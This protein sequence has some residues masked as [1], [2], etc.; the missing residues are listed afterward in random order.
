MA[1]GKQT[2]CGRKCVGR[3]GILWQAKLAWPMKQANMHVLLDLR[4]VLRGDMSA[5]RVAN[6]GATV[7]CALR[8]LDIDPA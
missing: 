3:A 2:T 6:E 1:A 8:R 5:V 7:L 4:G